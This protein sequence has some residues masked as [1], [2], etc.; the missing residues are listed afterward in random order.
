MARLDK[1]LSI[2]L[3]VT[4]AAALASIG[5][6]MSTPKPG[7][8]FTEFYIL[9]TEGKA[10]NYPKQVILGAS[11]DVIVG[12]VN[13]EYHPEKYQLEITINGVRN[14]EV[15][16]GTLAHQQTWQKEISF[17]VL[18]EGRR[19]AVEFWLYKDNEV[20]PYLEDPLRLYIDVIKLDQTSSS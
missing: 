8:K 1:V 16:I 3:V 4:I 14:K 6:L 18:Q 11:V 13:H 2:S 10:E 17:V 5:Y 12:V 9:D 19:Q 7:D 20:E 15:D